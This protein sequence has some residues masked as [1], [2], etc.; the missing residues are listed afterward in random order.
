MQ[1]FHAITILATFS[2][3]ILSCSGGS[4]KGA[5]VGTFDDFSSLPKPSLIPFREGRWDKEKLVK[6]NYFGLAK[7]DDPNSIV[8]TPQFS[9]ILY[10]PEEGVYL[11]AL[12]DE[13]PSED[14]FKYTIHI[15][16]KKGKEQTV[17]RSET[18]P[19]VWGHDEFRDGLVTYSRDG[20]D[21]AMDLLGKDVIVP[22]YDDLVLMGEGLAAAELGGKWTLISI[23]GGKAKELFAPKYSEI[24]FI[25]SEGLIRVQ[26]D[27][28]E[29]FINTKGEV[30]IPPQYEEVSSFSEGLAAVKIGNKYGY[31]NKENKEVIRAQYDFADLFVNGFARVQRDGRWGYINKKGEEVVSPR[32]KEA[33]N[34]INGVAPVR[35]EDDWGCINEKGELFIPPQY[36]LIWR[37]PS[38]NVIAVK[39]DNRWGFLDFK[40]NEL[41]SPRY[42]D[43]NGFGENGLAVVKI[44][45]KWG[46]VDKKG[47]VVI[48]P[49]YDRAYPFMPCV[50]LAVVY[51]DGKINYIDENGKP[52]L[53][54]G[55][56]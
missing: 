13:K 37:F 39:K 26:E 21:G 16:D 41:V 24:D 30:V 32:Y 10:A 33:G 1:T 17:L 50:E 47:R 19:I 9:E 25:I 46:Y 3:L 40:G 53:K 11:A 23:G 4:R 29:G 5:S 54:E 35:L 12:E 28:R 18:S 56:S 34:F 8:V 44:G 2:I 55:L 52:L 6:K 51:E 7:A 15:Y 14:K 31:I 43:F 42:E 22:Q 36:K 49:K 38:I 48:S 45:E 27:K 20:K